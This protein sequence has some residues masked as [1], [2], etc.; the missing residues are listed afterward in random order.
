[1]VCWYRVVPLI[2]IFGEWNTRAGVMPRTKTEPKWPF[3]IRT[4]QLG[5]VAR[6][7]LLQNA[8]VFVFNE[9]TRSHFGWD[10]SLMPN[11]QFIIC[12]NNCLVYHGI[13]GLLGF[14]ELLGRQIIENPTRCGDIWLKVKGWSQVHTCTYM[15][16]MNHTCCIIKQDSREFCCRYR[17]ACIFV[18]MSDSLYGQA[19]RA[20]E[21]SWI[22][23]CPFGS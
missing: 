3:C 15:C 22:L 7:M 16:F 4:F 8:L 17:S 20:Y 2:P 19:N 12:T 14:G 18:K 10:V 23:L 1:M 9:Q 13:Y 21:G 11:T 5:F 6:A